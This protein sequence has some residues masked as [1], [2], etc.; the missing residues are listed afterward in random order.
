MKFKIW[1][2]FGMLT[3]GLV[4]SGAQVHAGFFDIFRADLKFKL[5]VDRTEGLSVGDAVEF[6]DEA[7]RR[8][9]IG[10][11][12]AI[13]PAGAGQPVLAV[14]ID[15]RHKDL[16][17]QG[18]RVVVDRPWMTGGTVRV[19]IVTPADQADSPPLPSEAVVVARTAA[20]E[21]AEQVLGRVQ[22]FVDSLIGRSREY[23][24]RL[25]AEIDRGDLDRFVDQLKDTARIVGR[26]TREQKEKFATEVLPQME[27]LMDSARRR[28]EQ[29][30]DPHKG[31]ELER[32]FKRIKEELAV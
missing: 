21:T 16:V 13:A 32:E 20:A 11:I 1:T 15:A 8:Q 19:Y 6:E 14:T 18:S 30:K 26:Y 17:R 27:R 29:L 28:F 5:V 25:R 3:L 12:S 31:E 10:R 22:V 24:E 9:A 23:L 7:G 2:A 4:L